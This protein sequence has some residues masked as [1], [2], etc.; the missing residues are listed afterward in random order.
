MEVGVGV[1]VEVESFSIFVVVVV[2][3]LDLW[4]GSV[5]MVRVVVCDGEGCFELDFCA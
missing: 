3:W 5:V 1:E 2:D 4:C